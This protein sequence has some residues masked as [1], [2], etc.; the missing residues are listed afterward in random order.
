M[1]GHLGTTTTT[2]SPESNAKAVLYQAI[3]QILA[4]YLPSPQSTPGLSTTEYDPTTMQLFEANMTTRTGAPSDQTLAVLLPLL[5]LLS[6]LLFLL[7]IF[8]LFIILAKRKRGIVLRDDEGP[9]DLGRE[10]EL[11]GEG[12]LDGV[13]QRWLD[14]T[15]DSVRRG[16]IRAKSWSTCLSISLWQRM[17][18]QC[19]D[20]MA[21]S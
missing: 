5:I 11:E 6:S 9:L 1:T 20:S 18:I 10:E 21:N 12:G 19:N 7:L 4:S 8:L 15:D 2:A 17:L 13:E 14:T 3:D 16:Y